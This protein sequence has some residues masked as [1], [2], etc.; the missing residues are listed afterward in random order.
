MLRTYFFLV[1]V[2]Q[3][4]RATP[5]PVSTRMPSRKRKPQVAVVDWKPAP[6]SNSGAKLEAEVIGRVTVVKYYLADTE[7]DFTP[8]ILKSDA[9]ILWQNTTVTEATIAKMI[10]YFGC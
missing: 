9:I 8:A 1:N 3:H 5:I 4:G 6:A 10:N 7:A 2:H